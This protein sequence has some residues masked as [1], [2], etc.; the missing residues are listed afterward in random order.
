MVGRTLAEQGA[1]VLYLHT[2]NQMEADVVYNTANVGTRSAWVDLKT[3]DGLQRARELLATADVFVENLRG[4]TMDRLGLSD[5]EMMEI[6]PGIIIVKVRCFGSSGPWATRAGH[7]RQ[8]TATSGV[9]ISAGSV[10]H[11]KLPACRTT[12]D[13]MTGYEAATGSPPADPPRH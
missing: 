11:P 2:P 13:Y 1:D 7:D 8:G 9:A 5:E 4:G 6:R 12:N 10:E 3:K